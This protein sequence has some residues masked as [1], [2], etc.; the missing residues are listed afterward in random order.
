M[1][2]PGDPLILIKMGSE[3]EDLLA[4]KGW[5]TSC[6]TCLV[7]AVVTMAILNG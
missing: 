6:L 4:W 7:Q 2:E 3:G 1:N 5:Y